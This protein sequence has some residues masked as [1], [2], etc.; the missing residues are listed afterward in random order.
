MMK[1]NVA[2]SSD[3]FWFIIAKLFKG[4]SYKDIQENLLDRISKNYVNYYIS[5]E[6]GI[7]KNE[8]FKYYF[9]ILSQTVFYSIFYAFPKS[10]HKFN[11]ELKKDLIA[12][13]SYLFT[14]ITITNYHRYIKNWCLDLGSGNIFKMN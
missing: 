5:I 6:E 10:R 1:E 12:E 8:F 13:F 14:G 11:D 7:E 2:V 9:D 3:S 4:E